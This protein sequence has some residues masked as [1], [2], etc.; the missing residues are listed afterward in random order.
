MLSSDFK[1]YCKQW[2][3]YFTFATRAFSMVTT[4]PE[5]REVPV[6]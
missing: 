4:P 5:A 1:T 3:E 6:C 2:G